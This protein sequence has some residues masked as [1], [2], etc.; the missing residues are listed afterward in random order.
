MFWYL[1]NRAGLLREIESDLR[2]DELLKDIYE[3]KFQPIYKLNFLNLVDRPTV[4]VTLLKKGEGQ[5]GVRRLLKAVRTYRP[6]VV[7]FIGKIT[8]NTFSGSRHCDW[9]WQDDIGGFP[10]PDRSGGGGDSRRDH[11][12]T[13]Q[14]P[15]CRP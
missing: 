5:P 11:V 8:F 13:G 10:V 2:S 12:A 9:G 15:D 14:I 4:D 1:L 7:C 6:R 3:R